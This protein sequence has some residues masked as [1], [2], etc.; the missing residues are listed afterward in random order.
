VIHFSYR[1]YREEITER[2]VI[3]IRIEW[4]DNDG[5][6]EYGY[7]PGLFLTAFDTDKGDYRSFRYDRIIPI[8]KETVIIDF[9][10][11]VERLAVIQLVQVVG[12]LVAQVKKDEHGTPVMGFSDGNGGMVSKETHE[13]VMEVE[14][15]LNFYL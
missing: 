13:A 10:K 12:K 6:R 9:D 2:H 3:P 11:F 5:I 14:R 15:L 1:N 8:G 4:L 7:E